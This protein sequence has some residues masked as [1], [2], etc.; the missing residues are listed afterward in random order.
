MG[1]SAPSKGRS[2]LVLSGGGARGAYQ[3][4][5]LRG[6]VELGLVSAERSD[7]EIVVGSSAG[8]INAVA[9]AARADRF[10]DGIERLE[11]AWREMEPQQIF[12]TDLRSLG[13]IGF[14]W[15][16]D[17]SFGG[18]LRRVGP[19]S[20]LDTAPLRQLL[21]KR[22]PFDQL[23]SRVADGSLHALAVSATDLHTGTGV[24]FLQGHSEI[25]LWKRSRWSIERA[26]IGVEHVM[27]SSAIPVFFPSVQLEG[28]HFADGCIRNTAPLSPAINLGAERILAIGVRGTGPR[29][30]PAQRA[31]SAPSIAQIAGVL[32]DAVLLDA[33]EADVE[34]SDRV[35]RSVLSAP[36]N[37]PQNP[38]R[39]VDVLWLRPSRSVGDIAAELSDRIP[40]ILRYL[41]RGLGTDDATTELAS[42][43]LFD[44]VY[45]TRLLELGRS[46]VLE[47]ADAIRAFFHAPRP[48]GRDHA[49]PSQ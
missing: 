41:M 10:V 13:R 34:H 28:R 23:D 36:T 27:A 17:L 38:F 14:S 43:L 45:C 6:L 7:F 37:D 44:S 21:R 47:A 33:I 5:V 26:R 16:R 11:G 18:V 22:L 1:A 30:R 49:T 39:W 12:R 2:A 42:Y 40:G 24:V 29:S 25:S 4:G 48:S 31:P 32:L 9:L 46:D 15:V 3:V 8:A 35:N 19:K 20:L